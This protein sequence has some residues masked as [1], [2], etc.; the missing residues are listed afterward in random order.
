MTVCKFFLSFSINASFFSVNCTSIRSKTKNPGS[1]ETGFFSLS[2]TELIYL[3]KLHFKYKVAF[4][5]NGTWVA[6]FTVSQIVWNVER[7]FAA[8]FH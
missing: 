4:W 5:W 1:A 6:L 2:G 3:D 8:F 7:G